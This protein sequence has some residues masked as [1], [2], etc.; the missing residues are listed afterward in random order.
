MKEKRVLVLLIVL[1]I[2]FSALLINAQDEKEITKSYDCLKKKLNN[3]DNN[4]GGT[5]NTAE[6]SFSLLAI[7]YDSEL[8]GEC[9]N[10]LISKK[11]TDCWPETGSSS[12]CTVKATAIA[13]IALKKATNAD[14]ADS[15]KWLKSKRKLATELIWFLEI[16]AINATQCSVN[17][18]LFN[19]ADNKKIFGTDPLGLSKSYNNYWF[20]INDLTKNYT[21][22]CNNSFITTLIY[23]KPNSGIYYVSSE[24]HSAAASDSTNE[25]I[26]GYCFSTSGSCEYEGTLWAAMAMI[27]AGED[28]TPYIPYLTAMADDSVNAKYLPYAFLFM[29]DG[30]AI[31][32]LSGFL[33]LQKLNKYWEVSGNKFYDTA[34]ALLA[35]QT[36][37][38]QEATNAK[39]Y[40]MTQR[41]TT[42]DNDGCWPSDTAII[43]YSAWPKTPSTGGSGTGPSVNY[44]E[45]F[46]YT[47][48]SSSE[49]DVSDKLNNFECRSLSQKCCRVRPVQ[50]TCEQK[51]GL[52]CKNDEE[53]TGSTIPSSDE[54]SC[55][56]SGSCQKISTTNDC[57]D[58][59]GTCTSECGA[60]EQENTA[61]TN[62]CGVNEYCC[63]KKIKTSPNWWLI[64][65]LII[66]IILVILAIIFRNQ[67]K[68]WWFRTKTGFKSK[69]GPEPTTRPSSLPLGQRPTLMPRQIIPRPMPGRPMPG[70]PMIRPVPGRPAPTQ[71]RVQKDKEFEDTMKKL[72][73][74]S[75]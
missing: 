52:V 45:D 73:D 4:C 30:Q 6:N 53:C 68:I 60:D 34:I 14:I 63:F 48:T 32:Y 31:D 55:C 13:S 51:N 46:N 58:N 33:S 43:L 3:V 28:V 49:C 23:K 9:K 56:V 18:Q 29:I 5:A 75:K 69:K 71:G 72:K 27:E 65:L 64:I 59:E 16:D 36:G 57:E 74:M 54:S 39:N 20:Q 44:C 62:A 19:I 21:I 66:L 37:T 70:R 50:Q 35:L 11:K 38:Y 8:Q 42:G 12:I 22:S 40:L 1:G 17:G 67:L 24:T 26:N 10:A 41:V 2:L 15:I 47:C 25:F 61:Y 7:A